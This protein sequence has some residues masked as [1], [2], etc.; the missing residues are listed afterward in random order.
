MCSN[1]SLETE[2]AFQAEREV[3]LKQAQE[4][5]A[6]ISQSREEVLEYCSSLRQELSRIF[7]EWHAQPDELMGRCGVSGTEAEAWFRADNGEVHA[8]TDGLAFRNSKDI[9]DKDKKLQ[10]WGSI[11]QG[12][13]QGDGWIQ[14]GTQYLP[15]K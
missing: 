6:S 5:S 10:R 11:F 8:V 12:I 14:V 1:L 4:V 15:M 2:C 7:N 9:D 3:R 13:D